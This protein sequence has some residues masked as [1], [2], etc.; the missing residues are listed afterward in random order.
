MICQLVDTKEDVALQMAHTA[1]HLALVLKALLCPSTTGVLGPV[2]LRHN[3]SAGMTG[4]LR[5]S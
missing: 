2:V 4:C 1:I 5:V 3:K